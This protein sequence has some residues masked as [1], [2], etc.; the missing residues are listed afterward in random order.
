MKQLSMI[1]DSEKMPEE[2]RNILVLMFNKDDVQ[3]C[4]NYRGIKLVSHTMQMGGG[5]SV[6]TRLREKK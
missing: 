3:S 1:L 2:W 5:G 6:E 4:R